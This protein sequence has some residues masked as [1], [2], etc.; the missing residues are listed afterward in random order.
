V[1]ANTSIAA[2][3]SIE[4]RGDGGTRLSS[5]FG[6][7]GLNHGVQMNG[8]KALAARDPTKPRLLIAV[9]EGRSARRLADPPRPDALSDREDPHL[10]TLMS[11]AFKPSG[12][13]R[14]IATGPDVAAC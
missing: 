11:S 8:S 14:F 7:A 3:S 4:K 2:G 12:T 13:Q 6:E 10:R 1:C 9:A 5:E